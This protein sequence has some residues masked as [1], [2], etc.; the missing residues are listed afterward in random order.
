MHPQCDRLQCDQFCIDLPCD[1]NKCHIIEV[2]L[3]YGSKYRR[4]N[5]QYV[6]SESTFLLETNF[7]T[8]A[9]TIDACLAPS[10]VT[11]YIFYKRQL[12]SKGYSYTITDI[13][14]KLA[15]PST[16]NLNTSVF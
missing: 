9:G 14:P 8:V 12:E 15:T 6:A 13:Y 11:L 3:I 1:S 7:S 5:G 2:V 4:D 10:G 16:L